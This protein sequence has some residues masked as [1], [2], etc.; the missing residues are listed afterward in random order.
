MVNYSPKLIYN[1]CFAIWT[2]SFHIQSPP[3]QI[4]KCLSSLA[5]NPHHSVGLKQ[6]DDNKTVHVAYIQS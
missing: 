1:C 3:P 2:I 5:T 6:L 4:P